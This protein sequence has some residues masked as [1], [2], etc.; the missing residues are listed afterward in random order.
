VPVCEALSART[1]KK[2]L[3]NKETNELVKEVKKLGREEKHALLR[4]LL[5]G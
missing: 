4:R 2:P 1:C 3:T 5:P